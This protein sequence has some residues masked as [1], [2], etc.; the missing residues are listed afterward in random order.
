MRGGGI[1]A[2]GRVMGGGAGITQSRGGVTSKENRKYCSPPVQEGGNGW[3]RKR[4][5]NFW[6]REELEMQ[7]QNGRGIGRKR[8][9]LEEEQRP[10]EHQKNEG[11]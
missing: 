9:A 6:Q 7:P 4:G 8:E 1:L 2:G 3:R 10:K 11:A 5:E